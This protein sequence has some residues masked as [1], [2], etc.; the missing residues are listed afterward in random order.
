MLPHSFPIEQEW[1]QFTMVELHRPPVCFD[2]VC[3]CID[4]NDMMI[5]YTCNTNEHTHIKDTFLYK[6][7]ILTTASKRTRNDNCLND[8]TMF[9]KGQQRQ[10]KQSVVLR[11]F[12][13]GQPIWNNRKTNY[14]YIL[15]HKSIQTQTGDFMFLHKQKYKSQTDF[16]IPESRVQKSHNVFTNEIEKLKLYYSYEHQQIRKIRK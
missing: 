12:D 9:F 8:K 7:K 10:A 14:H 16:E 2:Q 4:A 5:Q 13:K 11:N 1:I 15:S 3:I 6:I